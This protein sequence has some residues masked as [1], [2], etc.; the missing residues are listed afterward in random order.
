M[1]DWGSYLAFG[2]SKSPLAS[3]VNDKKFETD[4]GSKEWASYL[5]RGKLGNGVIKTV[6]EPK[7]NDLSSSTK[8]STQPTNLSIPSY[9]SERVLLPNDLVPSHYDLILTPDFDKLEFD[10]TEEVTLLYFN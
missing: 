8:A 6:V 9:K 3:V 5:A 2:I 1:A 7:S 4:S 10:C